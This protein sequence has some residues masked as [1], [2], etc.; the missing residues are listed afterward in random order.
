VS[1]LRPVVNVVQF[2]AAAATLAFVVLLFV[3][4]PDDTGGG[5]GGG[6]QAA[7]DGGGGGGGDDGGGDGGGGGGIDGAAVFAANCAGCHGGD[8]GG[9]TGPQLSDGQVLAS[10]PNVEDQ[11]TLVT[12]GRG[13]MP[14]FGG[15]LSE[16]EIR[17][18]VEYTRTL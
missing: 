15:Q 13:G 5:G 3:N 9:G 6:G 17:A 14:A 8:G 12:G 10:F 11:I 18:V 16:D 4:E 1:G 7:D 2:V